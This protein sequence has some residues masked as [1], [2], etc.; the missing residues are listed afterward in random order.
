MAGRP[1]TRGR[2]VVLVAGIHI[3]V[4]PGNVV[5]EAAGHVQGAFAGVRE[6]W[7]A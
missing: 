5:I 6:V 2:G 1:F 3:E 7:C 4:R